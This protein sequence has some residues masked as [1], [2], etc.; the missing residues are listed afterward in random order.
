[1]NI[2]VG[3]EH[4]VLQQVVF[5]KYLEDLGAFVDV[6]AGLPDVNHLFKT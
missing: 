3:V 2:F 4:V 1:M 5:F 6:D